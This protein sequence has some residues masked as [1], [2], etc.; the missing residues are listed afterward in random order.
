VRCG[1]GSAAECGAAA[2]SQVPP[3]VCDRVVSIRDPTVF[4]T[5]CLPQL[6]TIDC[7]ALASGQGDPAC[8]GQLL[9]K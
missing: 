9:Y 8:K 1:F 2:Y 7:S 3:N 4:F 5:K 6:C